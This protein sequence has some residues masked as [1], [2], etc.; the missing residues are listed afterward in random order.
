MACLCYLLF[1][2]ERVGHWFGILPY[3]PVPATQ[4]I[5]K[6]FS[7]PER[8]DYAIYHDGLPENFWDRPAPSPVTLNRILTIPDGS[9]DENGFVFDKNCRPIF[10]ACQPLPQ[11]MKYR[12][13][14]WRDII[15]ADYR[16][17]YRTPRPYPGR[18]AVLTSGHQ[19]IYSH[20]LFDILP[21]LAKLRELYG[22]PDHYFLQYLHP[23]Q[24]ETLKYVGLTSGSHIINSAQV[25]WVRGDEL[26]VPCHQ[27]MFGYHHPRWVCDWLRD[28]FLPARMS[29]PNPKRKI[30]ISRSCAGK[31]M[32]TN[33][34]ELSNFLRE[35]GFAICL[36]ETMTFAEQVGLFSD[37][38]VIVAPHGSGL[39]NLVFCNPGTQVIELFP[40]RATDAYF[41]LSVDMNLQY[42][43]MK[44]RDMNVRP[45]VSDNFSI[46]LDDIRS[47]LSL[48]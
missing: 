31:R 42:T 35:Q 20:W 45:R 32:V 2:P 8:F 14:K 21:R 10:D 27:I 38:D 6:T 46:C 25:L 4:F 41:R 18:I 1:G 23:F 33:E 30:Y 22:E 19:H 7:P 37:A 11:R 16:K 47:A 26:V 15:P 13:K 34:E 29:S 28:T 5:D 40:A 17:Q 24:V 43:C 48:R 12:R 9:A 39:A 3:F 36:L 44:S